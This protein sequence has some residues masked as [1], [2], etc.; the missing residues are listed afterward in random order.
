MLKVGFISYL[1][2][3]PFYYPFLKDQQDKWQF[4]VKRPGILN[5]MLAAGELDISLVSFMEYAARKDQYQLIPG[6]ALS[7]KGYVDSVRLLSKVP[8]K[9]LSGCE[10][11]TTNASATSA[12]IMQILLRENGV[13]NFTCRTYEV[14]E[15]LPECTAA[16]TIGDEALIDRGSEFK[17][18]YDLGEMWQQ[19]FK[20][21]VVFAACA[22][23]RDSLK[24]KFN[25]ICEFTGL[26]QKAP[27]NSFANKAAFEQACLELYPEIKAPMAYLDRLHFEMGRE[28]EQDMQLVLDKAY[29]H[30]LIPQAVKPQYFN[31]H[32]ELTSE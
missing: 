12:A 31:P 5:K 8:L 2:A 20:R 22:V 29:E 3:F 7:S 24:S 21:N 23:R 15:G 30:G 25:E 1:N 16:L 9:E 27:A 18:V 6:I 4:S 32:M 13:K 17:Y 19:T 28:E 26:L 11:R 10:I 14:E